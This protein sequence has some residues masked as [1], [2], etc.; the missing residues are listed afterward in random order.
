MSGFQATGFQSGM[1]TAF[2]SPTTYPH[3]AIQQGIPY[4]LYGYFFYLYT[5]MLIP[6]YSLSFL[7]C[8]CIANPYTV[9]LAHACLLNYITHVHSLELLFYKLK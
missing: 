1:G 4:N 5:L 3:Y 9:V 7:P 6:L 2:A 8:M